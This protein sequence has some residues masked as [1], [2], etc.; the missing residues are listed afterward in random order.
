[1]ASLL[2]AMI[3]ALARNPAPLVL[4]VL[5]EASDTPIVPSYAQSGYAGKKIGDSL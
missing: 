2:L 4:M 1:M 5:W 3:P